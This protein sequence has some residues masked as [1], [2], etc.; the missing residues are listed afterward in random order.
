MGYSPW[1]CTE[2]DSTYAGKGSEVLGCRTQVFVFLSSSAG[3]SDVSLR[4][5][6]CPGYTGH[7]GMSLKFWILIC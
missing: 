7:L 4:T 3:D 1:G 5:S 6:V 2:L